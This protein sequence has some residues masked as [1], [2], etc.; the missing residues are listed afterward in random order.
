MTMGTCTH[1]DVVCFGASTGSVTAGTISNASGTPTYDWRNGSNVQ[2]GT[3]PTVSSLPAGT[4][5][6]TVTDDCGITATCTQIITQ[7]AA[8]MT[9]GT[10]NHTDVV[11]FGASTGSVIAGTLS[12]SAATPG[13]TWRNAGNT[14]V[15]TTSTV[16]NLPA[17]VYTLTVTD[18]C[19]T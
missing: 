13:Y 11:C 12:N 5:T 10:C 17:G 16:N 9:M 19:T 8:A 2:V 4:Y 3:T 18:G 7:P 1:V 14:I 15:G 6:L